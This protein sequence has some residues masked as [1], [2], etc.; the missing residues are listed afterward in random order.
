MMKKN[1]KPLGR[2]SFIS[3]A[4][5][6]SVGISGLPLNELTAR[7]ESRPIK[8][9]PAV[10]LEWRNKVDTM[11][12]RQLGRT[13]MMI[14]EV[15]NGGDPVRSE[16][17]RQVEIAIERGVNYLDMAPAYG[18]G[19]CETA[20]SKIIDSSSKRMK[21]F[22]TTKVSGYQGVRDGMYQDIFKGLPSE[23]QKKIMQ[24]AEEIRRERYVDKP[25]YFLVYWPN[26]ETSMDK[27]FISNAMVEDYGHLVDGS[28]EHKEK[29]KSSI[30]GSLKR[31]KTDHFDILMCPHGGNS[32]EEVMI[33]ETYETF[34]ELKKEGKVRFLGVSTHNDP[35][36]VLNA[37]VES[38]H[39]DA[40]MCAYNVI[41]GGYM[42]AAIKNAYENGVGVI[43]MKVAMAVATHHKPLQ[44]IPQWRVDKVKHIVPGDLKPP[45]K[46]YLWALQNPYLTAVISN[47]WDEQYINE[48]LSVVGRKVK[49][50]YG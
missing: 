50:N 6:A 47:L 36:G 25:G 33:P 4:S 1:E 12:Y 49:L 14:S 13:G 17:Y 45:L 18:N 7:S 40:V 23:K 2:R 38:G 30:E 42:E 31:A 32:R 15:V 41:N 27:C 29:I 24:R 20:Y 8:P 26:Q 37:A 5:A 22:M 44:P 34:Q 48:N 9:P 43:G 19:D 3:L 21:V 46:A 39:Y 35:A 28:K 16:T 10:A 11:S